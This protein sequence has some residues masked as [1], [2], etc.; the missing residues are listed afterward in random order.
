M[1]FL[2]LAL[3][4]VSALYSCSSERPALSE[5]LS[6]DIYDCHTAKSK[7]NNE[8]GVWEKFPCFVNDQ[9]NSMEYLGS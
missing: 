3:I 6:S 8:N 5:D 7:S 1:K 4:S 2:F 9:K